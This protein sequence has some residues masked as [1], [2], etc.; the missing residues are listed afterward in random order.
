MPLFLIK[1]RS[2]SRQFVQA[3]NELLVSGHVKDIVD[4]R[5]NGHFN[6][7]QVVIMVK[8]ALSCLEER[9]SRPTMNEIVRALLACDDHDNHPAYSW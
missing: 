7:E 1:I 2:S 6:P 3:V 9:N 5:L 8:L 4:T